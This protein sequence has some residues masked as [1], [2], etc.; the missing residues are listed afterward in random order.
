MF[1]FQGTKSTRTD[2]ALAQLAD[3]YRLGY[4]KMPICMAKTPN[5]LTIYL[6]KRV[7]PKK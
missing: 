1:S 4:D 3:F 7:L 5:S 6:F 2:A